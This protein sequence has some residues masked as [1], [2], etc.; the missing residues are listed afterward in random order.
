MFYIILLINVRIQKNYG[1]LCQSGHWVKLDLVPDLIP[2]PALVPDPVPILDSRSSSI[3]SSRFASRSRSS[4]DQNQISIS[5]P[6]PVPVPVPDPVPCLDLC[7]I[8]GRC[9]YD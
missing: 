7:L 8:P 4:S 1:T 2:D 3:S 9:A 6:V 5:D